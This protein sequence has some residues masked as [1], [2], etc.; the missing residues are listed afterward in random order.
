[1][2]KEEVVSGHVTS[3]ALLPSVPAHCVG[4]TLASWLWGDVAP[5]DWICKSPFASCL[6]SSVTGAL[7]RWFQMGIKLFPVP[8]VCQWPMPLTWVPAAFRRSLKLAGLSSAWQE[9]GQTEL[10]GCG[11]MAWYSYHS[12]TFTLQIRP[13]ASYSP[14]GKKQIGWRRERLPT[15]V[16]WPGEFHGRS[17]WGCKQSDTTERLSLSLFSLEE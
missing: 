1:M 7:S 6:F 16:F 9:T 17:P 13:N 4:L 2:A 11:S 10:M 12:D 3:G 15:S 14:P 5:D 8:S